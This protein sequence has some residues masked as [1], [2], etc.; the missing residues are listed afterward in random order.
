MTTLQ[1]PQHGRRVHG[2]LP[3]V[4]VAVAG[5]AAARPR[6]RRRA[7]A[8]AARR[9]ALVGEAGSPH[10]SCSPCSAARPETR[11]RRLALLQ[12][13]AGDEEIQAGAEALA[14]LRPVQWHL[15][16]WELTWWV[17]YIFRRANFTLP[18]RTCR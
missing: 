13:Q 15:D 16:F 8:A 18:K 3:A 4:E 9:A 2:A 10:R 5:A 12:A 7:T 1:H 14:A 17:S 11:H 6:P